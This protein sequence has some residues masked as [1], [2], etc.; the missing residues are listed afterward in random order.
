P[1]DELAL[2]AELLA[3]PLA[4]MLPVAAVAERSQTG[5]EPFGAARIE[6]CSREVRRRSVKRVKEGT[7]QRRE[8]GL[9][10]EQAQ[11]RVEQGVFHVEDRCILSRQMLEHH[12]FDTDIQS[13]LGKT[14]IDALHLCLGV[15]SRQPLS[16]AATQPWP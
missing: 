10:A 5:L 1:T 9:P 8:D 2:G 7:G 4:D 13:R 11:Q 14:Q 6:I 3:I 16:E 15:A 12:A